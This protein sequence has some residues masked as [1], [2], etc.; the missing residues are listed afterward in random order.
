M[1]VSRNAPCPCGSGKKYKRC[2]L[3]ETTSEAHSIPRVSKILAGLGLVGGVVAY[4]ITNDLNTG[5]LI[6]VGGLV[7]AGAWAALGNPP[8]SKGPGNPAGLG[9]G[10]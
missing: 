6:A 9:F 3:E 4:G 8:S 1:T 2:C 7:A 5:G 10:R